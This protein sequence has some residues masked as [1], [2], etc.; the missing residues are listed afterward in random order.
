M[1]NF[2]YLHILDPLTYEEI[3]TTQFNNHKV[4]I[5]LLLRRIQYIIETEHPEAPSLIDNN[6]TAS[7]TE[8]NKLLFELSPASPIIIK[9]R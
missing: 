6:P 3:E 8:S 9:L 5:D 2:I 4:T 1:T 7:D